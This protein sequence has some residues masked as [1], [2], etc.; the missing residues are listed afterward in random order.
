LVI[1]Q[2]SPKKHGFLDEIR[3]FCCF[4]SGCC[5]KTEVLNNSINTRR[6]EMPWRLIGFILLFGIFLAFIT[7]NL[8]NVSDISF[9]FREF[10][11]VPV[12]LT[13][14]ASFITG[15]L[16]ALPFIFSLRKKKEKA[17]KGGK[18]PK[19]GKDQIGETGDMPKGESSPYGID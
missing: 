10:T 7:V 11:G 12:Y 4:F 15:M 9:G 16:C 2:V 18:P 3:V 8:G 17:G 1:E 14:F 19:P 5:L 13:V 6:G